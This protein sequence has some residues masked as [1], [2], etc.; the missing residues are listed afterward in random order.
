[1]PQMDK[2]MGVSRDKWNNGIKRE[3]PTGNLSIINRA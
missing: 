1:M 3:N 2:S